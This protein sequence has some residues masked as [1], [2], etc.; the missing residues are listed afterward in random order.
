MAED[1]LIFTNLAEFKDALIGLVAKADAGCLRGITLAAHATQAALMKE[2]PV[3]SGTLRRSMQVVGPT[4]VGSSYE[5]QIG[6]TVIYARRVALGFHGSDSL[7][8]TFD[9]AGNPYHARAVASVRYSQ[10]FEG[11]IGAALG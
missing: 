2:A 6:P 10:I 9:Q 8:R 5:A 3:V 11:A 7:G 4:K 1:G